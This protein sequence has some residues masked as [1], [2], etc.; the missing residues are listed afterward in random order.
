LIPIS[1]VGSLTDNVNDSYVA[2]GV[3]V[4]SG[5]QSA[6]EIPVPKGGTLSNLHVHLTAA[7][8]AGGKWTFT[9]NKN[10]SASALSCFIQNAGTTCNDSSLVTV[11]DGDTIDLHVAPFSTPT[12]TTI[13][14]WSATITP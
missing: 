14:S 11:V 7:P 1:G 5:T 8:G 6:V 13:V 9:V 10:G 4:V 12:V 3:S 2:Y